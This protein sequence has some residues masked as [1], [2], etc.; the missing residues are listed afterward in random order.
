MK[1]TNN[2]INDFCNTYEQSSIFLD[3]KKDRTMTTFVNKII[4]KENKIIVDKER[5]ELN[6]GFSRLA[7][8]VVGSETA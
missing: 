3:L 8:K 2:Q 5:M 1:K 4:K 6:S 7:N